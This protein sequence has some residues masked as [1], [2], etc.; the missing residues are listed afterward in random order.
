MVFVDG[1]HRIL[2]VPQ[3]GVENELYD[4]ALLVGKERSE[5]VIH[6]PVVGVEQAD[7]LGEIGTQNLVGGLFTK[8]SKVSDSV[9]TVRFDGGGDVLVAKMKYRE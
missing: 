9:G 1:G 4:A 5:R 3:R 8:A 6:V 2:D 7:D